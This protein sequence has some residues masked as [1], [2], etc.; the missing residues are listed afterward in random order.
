[1]LLR[2]EFNV[3]SQLQV[4]VEADEKGVQSSLPRKRT[5]YQSLNDED[6]LYFTGLERERFEIVYSMLEKFNPIEDNLLWCK[7]NA[8]LITL[9]KCRHNLDFKMMEFVFEVSRILISEIFKD[10]IEK[11]HFTLKQIDIWNI[12]FKDSKS[13][14]CI[15]GCAEFFVLSAGDPNVH[16]L[17]TSFYKGHPTF[18]LLASCDE[19]GAVNFISDVFCGSPSNREIVVKS[20]LLNKLEK[21]D[22]VMADNGFN[23]TDLL[24]AKGMLNIPPLLRGKEQLS[25]F[26]V[27]K[28][29]IIANRR[30][31]IENVNCRAAKNKILV[32]PMQKCLW[33]YADQI[34]YVSFALVNFYKPLKEEQPRF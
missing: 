20:G 11:L 24:E 12:S 21:E 15:L 26:E 30:K 16:Q 1:M 18:K 2:L 10:V 17:T 25:E 8:L 23:I 14:R 34:I 7:K 27:M 9:H 19:L 28:T 13:Y 33:P 22:S 5:S 6:L 4:K 32:T 3:I 29:R 31:V